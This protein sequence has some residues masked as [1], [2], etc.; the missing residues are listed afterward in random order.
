MDDLLPPPP[1]KKQSDGELL[2]PP[3]KKKIVQGQKETTQEQFGIP[4]P[5]FKNGGTN[6][7]SVVS[8]G[9]SDLIPTGKAEEQLQAA[10]QPY[11]IK[12]PV[13][14]EL[15]PFRKKATED[16]QHLQSF[17]EFNP[18]AG[19]ESTRQRGN[20][21]TLPINARNDERY[22]AEVKQGQSSS[23]LHHAT[24]VAYSSFF[25]NG[26]VAKEF[27]QK[28]YEANNGQLDQN[29]E[30]LQLAAAKA[31]RFEAL[32]EK[33]KNKNINELAIDLA[34]ENSPYMDKL[35]TEL[36]KGQGIEGYG[37]YYKNVIPNAMQGRL[38]DELANDPDMKVV[39]EDDPKIKAQ[40]DDL[41]NNIYKYYPEYGKTKVRNILSQEYER[42]R[43]N[44]VANPIFWNSKYLDKLSDETFKDNPQLKEIADQMKGNWNEQLN[45]SGLVDE[46]ASGASSTV[47]GMGESIKDAVGLGDTHAERIYKGLEQE[48]SH[49]D[50]GVKGWKKDLG[51]AANFGGMITA[52]AAGGVPLKGLGLSPAAINATITADTFYDN[53]LNKY[54]LMY[55]GEQWK[56]RAG[57]LLSTAAYASVAKAFPSTKLADAVS[58][59]LAP[60]IESIVSNLN[61]EAVGKELVKT[62]AQK[63]GDV[64]K[65]TASGTAE[66]TGHMIAVTTFQKALDDSF[67]IDPEANKKYH[68]DSEIL[69]V[70]RNMV[71][72][73]AFPQAVIAIGNRNAVGKSLL[74]AA[75]FPERSLSA[76]DVMKTKGVIDEAEYDKKL[77][78][79]KYLNNLNQYLKE[80]NITPKN[81]ARFLLEAMN[82]K[83][84]K[85]SIVNSPETA[86]TRRTQNEIRGHQEVQDKILN[87]E[88][89]VGIEEKKSFTEPETKAIDAI[90]NKDL[91]GTALEMYGKIISD[92]N[93]SP[94]QK[95]MAL[96]EISDQLLATGTAEKVGTIL[97]KDASLAIEDLGHEAPKETTDLQ[98]IHKEEK[99]SVV[100]TGPAKTGRETLRDGISIIEPV[101]ERKST[102]VI[103]PE[104][105]KVA[106]IIPLKK[107]NETAEI[108]VEAK[109]ESGATQ[110]TNQDKQ[111]ASEGAGEP[112]AE[113]AKVTTEQP[114][115][116]K[117]GV[118]HAALTELAKRLDLKEPERG[119]YLPP[120]WYAD[121]GRRLLAEGASPD[122]INNT[123]NRLH[124]RISV[125]RAHLENLVKAADDIAKSNPEGVN[126]DAYKKAW[127][128]VND[129]AKKVKSLGTEAHMAM[130]SLQG[131]RD[132]DTDSFTAVKN[133]LEESIGEPANKVQ[134]KKIQELTTQNKALK[135]QAQEL[136]AKLIIATDASIG[137]KAKT[138]SEKAKEVANKLRQKAKL[139]RPGSFSVA[140]PASLVWDGA[141]EVV[142]KGIEAGGKIADAIAEGIKYIKATD[143]YKGLSD[144][145]K[146]EAENDFAKWNEQNGGAGG[147]SLESLQEK[148]VDKEDNKFSVDEAKDIWSYAKKNYLDKGVSY[149]DTLVNVANDLGLSW[150]QISEAFTSK[151]VKPISDEM[152][153]KQ[154]D[155]RKSQIATKNWVDA[156]S[157]SAPLKALRKVSQAFRGVAVF[158]HGGIFI[159]THAGMTL[160]NPSQWRYVIPAFIRGWKFAY[161]NR[162][163]YERRVEQ[164]RNSPNYVI[165]QRAGLK[166]NPDI[167]NTEE[168]QKSQE[169]FK[170]IG[171][172]AG[173][174]GFNAIKVLR[175]DLFDYHYKKLSQ[176][177]KDDPQSAQQIAKLVNNATGATNLKLPEWV[178]EVSFAGGMEAAR[179]G[180]LTRNPARATAIAIKAL[181]T[182]GKA[183]TAEKVFAK[184]WARR[185]GEQ[186]GTMAGLLAAN[187]AIQNTLN[188]NNPVNVTNPN[189]PDYL[190]FKFGDITIDPTSGMRGA[191]LFAYGIGKIPFES[192]KELRGDTRTQAAGK[193]T[194]SYGRGK[195]A[196]L[197]S[198]IADFFA[199]SDFNKNPLP[200]SNDKPGAGHHKLTWGEYAWEKAPLPIAHAAQE[201]Y[202][203]ALDN[204]DGKM[205]KNHIVDGILSGILSGGTGLRIGQYNAEEADH[206]PFTEEDKK[207][208]TFKYFLDK[209]L[210]LPN[211]T[212]TSEKV[213][214]Q[215]T[216]TEKTLSEYP[217]EVRDSYTEKHKQHLKQE[218]AAIK[219]QGFVFVD[220]YGSVSKLPTAP[221]TIQA[222]Q[223]FA[224]LK[225]KKI[226][227]LNDKELEQV[228]KIAQSEATEKTK[229]ELFY[230][231]KK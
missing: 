91:S 155:Y 144:D 111:T 140:T 90:K 198:T 55:P 16:Y 161:G 228:L 186:I 220:A 61:K 196:P 103:Q 85:E 109:A 219:K 126:S 3:P 41:K 15:A 121:R 143:W 30:T 70:A 7:S 110:T 94:D 8:S 13:K 167:V 100:V 5:V 10:E 32:K 60:E 181:V 209:G 158:G 25:K 157:K 75:E 226:D 73:S 107:A 114:E 79:I 202:H 214:D 64:L 77:E 218:L 207:D 84:K 36:E 106:D 193:Q 168:F 156:Q 12:D 39:G 138:S 51:T 101:Q 223:D 147:D 187:V 163:D 133:N 174:K 9:G 66:A 183:T 26:K 4:L 203:A 59:K 31:Q 222:A 177:E 27:L 68:P 225:R 185:V 176:V 47:K 93:A 56:A 141:V 227:D 154:S 152:W 195:L 137:G 35:I 210:E 139:H 29:N 33:A 76:L 118:H 48:Y 112:P 213:K 173:I 151:K 18:Y 215:A 80:N 123:G 128:D 98:N 136:E 54:S 130:T 178:N 19:S 57:A 179:W 142:A 200:F 166:N 231:N 145:K 6:G 229:K 190:K 175:Q 108:P 65:K 221:S 81:K 43:S 224:L 153:K 180:K 105:N 50:S 99:S 217:K 83:Y 206:S 159:G 170:K 117:V 71:I 87:G 216:H 86:V 191:A 23:Q 89:V 92:E 1:K 212:L 122:E 78:D 21:R 104:E 172:E 72:G 88:D 211:T 205:T 169:I 115:G 150:K 37:D 129:Y 95:K 165:A 2:P 192:K 38:V 42:R 189:K 63:L 135:K 52:M 74:S 201:M 46:F 208:P 199:Q 124:D 22:Q 82:E 134:E 127:G 160:F 44:L 45:T 58:G 49:V 40:L 182:P 96:R 194:F 146:G 53:E 17:G 197:Y 62:A 11:D 24:D 34:R 102:S 120:E 97:G 131:E 162:G 171:G 204:G 188:P 28:E 148:F 149:R 132:I 164:L 116:S 113:G 125:G 67:G 20:Q 230:N 14:S 69:D 184:V 119:H